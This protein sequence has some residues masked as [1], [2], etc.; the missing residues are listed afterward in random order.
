M[1]DVSRGAA[2]AGMLRNRSLR[3]VLVAFAVFRPS[4]SAQWIAILVYAYGLHGTGQMG[5]AAVILVAPAAVFAPFGAQLGDRMPRQRALAIGYL[6]QGLATGMTALTL[7]IGAPSGLVYA[8]AALATATI[9]LIRPVHL[10]IL[11]ELSRS[12]EEL[13]AANSLS[14]TIEGLAMFVGPILAGAL[15]ATMGPG[16]VFGAASLGLTVVGLLIMTLERREASRGDRRVRVDRVGGALGGFRALGQWEGARLLLGFVAGQTVVVAALDILTVVLAFAVL[17]MGPG[18]PG[19]LWAALGVG[20]LIG[21][22]GTIVLIGRDRLSPAFFLGVMLV[23]VPIAFVAGAP[24]PPLAIALLA[25][26]GIGKSFFDVA[27]RILL[28]RS[29]DDGVLASVFGV[30]EGLNMAAYAVGS[31]AAPLLVAAV[32]DRSAFV[33]VGLILPTLAVLAVR[34]ILSLDRTGPRAKRDDLE[35]L[36]STAIFSAL[37]G[38]TLERLAQ[39]LIVLDVAEGTVVMREGDEG[40]RLYMIAEGALDVSRHGERLASLGRGSYVGEIALL[41]DVPRTA[42]VTARTDVSLRALERG[43]FLLAMT[44][45]AAGT[46]AAEEEADRR[47]RA[48]TPPPRD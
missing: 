14:S 25:V 16:A 13:V 40:D 27:A 28:Q 29:V 21:S 7:G 4:E 8:W 32:G 10:A 48:Q 33:A 38:L 23:G 37:D 18:G 46:L 35:L 43:P 45:S 17:A 19:L 22:A 42:T 5:L 47:L 26:S 20:G 6:A 12:P 34:R 2:Y 36:R 11:P 15:L 31:I 1:R 39:Q 30:Q 9:T 44:G 41:R 24:G 3:R